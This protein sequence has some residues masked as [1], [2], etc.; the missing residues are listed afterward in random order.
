MLPTSPPP[1]LPPPSPPPPRCQDLF[2]LCLPR[3]LLAAAPHGQEHPSPRWLPIGSIYLCPGCPCHPSPAPHGKPC[4]PVGHHHSHGLSPLPLPFPKFLIAQHGQT[5][6]L[7]GQ[8]AP[9][10]LQHGGPCPITPHSM[11]TNWRTPPKGELSS[12]LPLGKPKPWLWGALDLAQGFF[13]PKRPVHTP[14]C[15]SGPG[16]DPKSVRRSPAGCGEGGRDGPAGHDVY[17]CSSP[18]WCR[19]TSSP[20]QTFKGQTEGGW[21]FVWGVMEGERRSC[22]LSPGWWELLGQ[23]RRGERTSHHVPTPSLLLC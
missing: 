3:C 21:G 18:W 23:A 17:G 5:D 8:R 1:P 19:C 13:W 14:F 10:P 11:G 7:K 12:L 22:C 6:G 9:T 2:A 16:G 4:L 20:P 15:P